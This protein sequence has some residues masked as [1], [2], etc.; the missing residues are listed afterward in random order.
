MNKNSPI[1]SAVIIA[2]GSNLPGDYSSPRALLE[3]AIDRLTPAG[4]RVISRSRLWRSAA[5]PDPTQPEYLNLVTLVETALEPIAI[6]HTLHSIEADFGRA[7]EALNE[8]RTLDLDLIAA[9]R[10]VIQEGGITVPHPRA[11]A[12]LF[13]MGPL[14]EIAPGWVH[15]VLGRTASAL[16]A[17]A[18][19]GTDAVPA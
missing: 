12:R 14:A 5:W 10:R 9:G 3:A 19:V 1:D 11:H 6:L 8:A 4:L 17:G 15:P 13:V 16:A 18:G 2:L 7:R